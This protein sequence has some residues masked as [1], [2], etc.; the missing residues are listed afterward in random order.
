MMLYSSIC[1]IK[2]SL[3]YIRVINIVYMINNFQ[4]LFL[5]GVNQPV[6]AQEAGSYSHQK[7]ES[8]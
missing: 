6:L 8:I 5:V 1:F 3:Q 2:A 4:N 7:F